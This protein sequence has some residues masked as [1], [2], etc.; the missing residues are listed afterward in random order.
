MLFNDPF[1]FWD[2]VLCI[3]VRE[4]PIGSDIIITIPFIYSRPNGN[5]ASP[6]VIA[7]IVLDYDLCITVGV[8][9]IT[10][11]PVTAA[12]SAALKRKTLDRVFQLAQDPYTNVVTCPGM[13]EHNNRTP[14]G[15]RYEIHR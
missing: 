13:K 12:F 15:H 7:N 8:Q 2:H 3:I 11:L 1:I 4:L 6:I 10:Y 14:A 9:V 5:C